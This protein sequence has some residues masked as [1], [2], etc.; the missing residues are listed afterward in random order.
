MNQSLISIF[1]K[2]LNDNKLSD[3]EFSDIENNINSNDIIKYIIEKEFMTSEDIANSISQ[4][5]HKKIHNVL[6]LKIDEEFFAKIPEKLIKKYNIIPT[7][8]ENNRVYFATYNPFNDIAM[9]ELKLNFSTKKIIFNLA[10][11]DDV[12]SKMNKMFEESVNFGDFSDE[13]LENLELESEKKEDNDV[14]L[15][16]QANDA[17]I[18]KFSNKILLDSIRLDASDIHLEP[19][20]KTYRI[21]YRVDGVL[22]THHKPN[23]SLE[24]KLSARFKI[25]SGCNIAEKRKP[26]DGRI[27]LKLSSTKAIDFRVNFVPTLF[28][29][30]IVLRKLDASS[31]KMGIDALGYAADQKK[32]FLDNLTKPQGMI[33]VT[34]PTGSGKTVSLYTGLNIIN[35]EEINISTAED[36]VEINLEGINQVNVN[37]AQGLNFS[38]ALRAFLR[39]DPDVIMVGEIRD[40]ETAGIAIKAA[41]TGHMVMSTL[42][43]NSAAET[44]TRLLNMGVAA[45][46][47]ATTINLIIAQRLGRKLCDCKVES[48]ISEKTLLNNGFTQDQID[49]GFKI[50]ERSEKGCEKCDGNGYKGRVG[51]YEV[52]E[53]TKNISEAIMNN[54]TSIELKN[55]QI[56]EGFNTLRQSAIIK[57]VEGVT[58]LEEINRVTQ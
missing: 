18:I 27:K 55:I 47:V 34:G 50:Y 40:L 48:N 17:P 20:E 13:E 31:A 16:E 25:M 52:V 54:A 43:T 12:L 41:Q 56:S 37:P 23:K 4:T 26:Q 8:E 32:L 51:I 2:Q 15:K 10:S 36:P 1:R 30:K 11:Y 42:H 53:I 3:E 45:F 57:V 49:T 38:D 22:K 9:S 44:I 58:S 14:N 29:E 39:Q 6:D 19:Y 21:R 28:G 35:S 33:L 5:F 24:N 7:H 46:N